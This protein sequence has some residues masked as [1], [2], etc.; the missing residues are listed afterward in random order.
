MPDQ[1]Q[2]STRS[3]DDWAATTADTVERVVGVVRDRVDTVRVVARWVVFGVL[4]AILGLVTLVLVAII[5]VRLGAAYLPFDPQARRVW[6]T[7]AILGGIFTLVGLFVWR[8]R[9]APSRS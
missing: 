1:V 9:S 6:V 4:A 7:E 8:K 3:N 5:A 2:A